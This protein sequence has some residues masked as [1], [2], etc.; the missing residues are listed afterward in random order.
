MFGEPLEA[1]PKDRGCTNHVLVWGHTLPDVGLQT[2]PA[3]TLLSMRGKP[4]N[5]GSRLQIP[6][7]VSRS[8]HS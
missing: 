7:E 3:V 5:L 2:T 1:P 6:W 4:L 8:A